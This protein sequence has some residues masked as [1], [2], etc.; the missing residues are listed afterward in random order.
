MTAGFGARALS[1][2]R[3]LRRLAVDRSEPAGLVE[4]VPALR[5]RELDCEGQRWAG[6]YSRLGPQPLPDPHVASAA[7]IVD[8]ATYCVSILPWRPCGGEP[9]WPGTD[10]SEKTEVALAAL[11]EA[12]QRGT[13]VGR[14]LESAPVRRGERRLVARTCRDPRRSR[15]STCRCQRSRCRTRSAA[16]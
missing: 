15:S 12:A 2:R 13:R 9:T 14:G 6:V 16:A 3:R 8:G 11:L 1:P 7:A 4:G 5:V 10:L